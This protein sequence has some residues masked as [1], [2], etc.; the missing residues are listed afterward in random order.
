[1]QFLCRLHFILHFKIILQLLFPCHAI[2]SHLPRTLLRNKAI[3]RKW[4]CKKC[5][6]Y[7][8]IRSIKPLSFCLYHLSYVLFSII[9]QFWVVETSISSL[10]AFVYYICYKQSNQNSQELYK[11]LQFFCYFYV[12]LIDL[13]PFM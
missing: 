5:T 9:Y 7:L 8:L 12:N 10:V 2:T 6:D 1:V 4:P 11:F 3:L 13:Q